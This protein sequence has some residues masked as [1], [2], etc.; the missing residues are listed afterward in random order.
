M[1]STAT[2]LETENLPELRAFARSQSV[3]DDFHASLHAVRSAQQQAE[4][5]ARR[6]TRLA[7]AAILGGMTLAVVGWATVSRLAQQKPIV[8]AAGSNGPAATVRSSP[9]PTPVP[10]SAGAVAAAPIE[11]AAPSDTA[12]VGAAA[13]VVLPDPSGA[14]PAANDDAVADC[15]RAF[16]AGRW[17][18]VASACQ[19]AFAVHPKDAGLA[20]R[21]AQAEHRGGHIAESGTWAQRAIAIDANLPEAYA[22]VARAEAHAGNPH[23]E[24]AAYRHYLTLAPRGWH[25]SEA[26]RALALAPL[27]R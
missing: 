3:A 7:R 17:H 14:A 26:R 6:Q 9:T 11:R 21:V 23:A 12:V 10:M 27:A 15:D 19:A 2:P 8:S 20:M 4:A 5:H 24:A 16:A 25:A 22:I 1:D 13:A 18:T